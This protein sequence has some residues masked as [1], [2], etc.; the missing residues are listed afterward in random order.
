MTLLLSP[1]GIL[2]P[3]LVV[4]MLAVLFPYNVVK[5][6][7]RRYP[8]NR[9]RKFGWLFSLCVTAAISTFALALMRPVPVSWYGIA[10][11]YGL[12][13]LAFCVLSKWPVAAPA[14][15]EERNK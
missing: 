15:V 10:V 14:S 4:L 5:R 9:S 6:A 12:A 13:A 11:V 2:I 7:M 1:L 3:V 8:I